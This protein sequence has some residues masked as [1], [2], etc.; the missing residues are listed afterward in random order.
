MIKKSLILILRTGLLAISLINSSFSF[1]TSNFIS[2]EQVTKDVTYL[3]SDDLKGRG[4]FSNEINQAANYIAQRFEESGLTGAKGIS[5]Q[6]FLQKYKIT[7]VSSETLSLVLNGK[8]IVAE[9]LTIASNIEEIS[10]AMSKRIKNNDFSIHT[11][12]KDDDIR[13]LI[14]DINSEGGEHLILLH[15]SHKK[16]FKRYQQRFSHGVT[17]LIQ[18]EGHQQRSGTIVIALCETTAKEVNNVNILAVN[19][20]SASE[21]TNVIA[22]LPGKTKPNEVVLYSAHYDHLG[23]A[24]TKGDNIFNGADDN[25]S[26]TT[27]II[28]IAQY[29]AKK[30]NNARTLM[31]AA[32]SAEEL[33]GFGSQYFSKQLD[34]K[35]ITAMINIEMIGKPSKFGAGTIWMTGMEKSTLG[36]QLNKVLAN[37]DKEI[38]PDPYPE[39]GLFYRSDNAALA[40]LGVPAH[41]FSSTQLDKD[42]H[43]HNVSD[44]LSSLNLP[45]LHKVIEVLAIATQPLVEGTITPSR[46]D[47]NKVKH[48]GLIY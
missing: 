16:I 25:A 30:G 40:R 34:P 44:D 45:S 17:K 39:Q 36:A 32:F 20:R 23:L 37:L 14:S 12:G 43:Y 42:K 10:W 18:N 15:P 47:K 22:I 48:K 13:T 27:A 6:G 3:A 11:I 19:K 21:L 24:N 46:I 31:F 38:Y 33:G 29:Y 1:A 28:N 35:T 5:A 2:L 4:N 26:G 9:N 8:E 7:K 41:S